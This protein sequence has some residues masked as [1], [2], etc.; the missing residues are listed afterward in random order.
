VTHLVRKAYPWP[1]QQKRH[2]WPVLE[3]KKMT[4]VSRLEA[5]DGAILI[6]KG[7]V[8]RRAACLFYLRRGEKAKKDG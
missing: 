5:G 3:L 1:Q 7:C 2:Q 8:I 6:A 4:S